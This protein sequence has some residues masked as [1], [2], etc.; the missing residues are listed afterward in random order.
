MASLCDISMTEELT[1]QPPHFPDQ[2]QEFYSFALFADL[3]IV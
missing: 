1:P 2:E 3:Q